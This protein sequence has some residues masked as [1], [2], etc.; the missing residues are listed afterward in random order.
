MTTSHHV[1]ADDDADTIIDLVEDCREI[2]G[3]LG[4]F[5]PT[6][7]RIPEARTAPPMEISIDAVH[8]LAG[9]EEYGS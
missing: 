2:S 7:I 6:V 8:A 5:V 4:S 3:V 9:Y 1:P